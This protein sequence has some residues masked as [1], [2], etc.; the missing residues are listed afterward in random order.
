[1]RHHQFFNQGDGSRPARIANVE[2]GHQH[3]NH[4]FRIN[5]LRYAAKEYPIDEPLGNPLL[6]YR[7][8]NRPF[9]GMSSK[10]GQ[11]KD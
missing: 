6:Q 3:L 1:M 2:M 8:R 4:F 5:S 7:I 9:P 11:V 10:D